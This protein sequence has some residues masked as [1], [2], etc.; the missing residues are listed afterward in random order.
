VDSL[1]RLHEAEEERSDIGGLRK[2]CDQW[3]DDSWL[4]VAKALPLTEDF[5]CVS[6]NVSESEE[7]LA[8]VN[9][10]SARRVRG[11]VDVPRVQGVLDLSISHLSLGPVYRRNR[12][13]LL[14]EGG[15]R[16]Q[17][18]ERLKTLCHPRRRRQRFRCREVEHWTGLELESVTVVQRMRPIELGGQID[19][20]PERHFNLGVGVPVRGIP[21]SAALSGF[22]RPFERMDRP[23]PENAVTVCD[24]QLRAEVTRLPPNEARWRGNSKG[25]GD[26]EMLG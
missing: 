13:A 12:D 14:F 19:V 8:I 6:G 24:L 11:L 20:A 5:L 3:L 10:V 25:R 9:R 26:P 7:S 18:T 22:S 16:D 23:R 4:L 15:Q 17:F 2:C 1:E 21:F